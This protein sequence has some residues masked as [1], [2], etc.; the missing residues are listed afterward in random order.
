MSVTKIIAIPNK[1]HLIWFGPWPV[2][3]KEKYL[4]NLASWK[5][6]NP[7]YETKLWTSSLS[8]SSVEFIELQDFCTSNKVMLC[9]IDTST[10]DSY[11][12]LAA[13]KEWIGEL[14]FG[15]PR[16]ASASDY[17]RISILEREGGHYFDCDIKPLLT[18]EDINWECD[19]GHYQMV[20]TSDYMT[21]KSSGRALTF[22]YCV[23]GA[24][25]NNP[26]YIASNAFHAKM[27][28]TIFDAIQSYLKD[29]SIDSI[30]FIRLTG[31]TIS[32][33]MRALK[34][35]APHYIIREDS[36]AMITG[37][38][39]KDKIEVYFDRSYGEIIE[40]FGFLPK[41]IQRVEDS[42]YQVELPLSPNSDI[43]KVN[44]LQNLK[45][46]I[47]ITCTEYMKYNEKIWFSIFHRHGKTGRVRAQALS[48]NINAASTLEQAHEH[49][50]CFFDD[51][52][53]GNTYPHSLK[54]MLLHTLLDGKQTLQ[55][56]SKKFIDL[57]VSVEPSLDDFDYTI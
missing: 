43:E 54:T 37:G 17:L 9:N 56:V 30:I 14:A 39:L 23:M 45:E 31:Q 46:K 47:S 38:L 51:C 24:T 50:K 34:D 13:V 36:G 7:N 33:V 26:V 8:M 52:K 22:Q 27:H 53:N 15:K 1:I 21:H 6:L 5:R 29:N 49:L 57:Y 12:N 3:H 55:E 25:S 4:I 20:T 42:L 19:H 16:F 32:I 28:R 2:E 11:P 48:D 18:I 10:Y 44:K 35:N 40:C 41:A